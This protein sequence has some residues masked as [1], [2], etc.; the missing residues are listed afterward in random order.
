[1]DILLRVLAFAEAHPEIFTRL[2]DLF[3]NTITA[4]PELVTGLVNRF[5]PPPPKP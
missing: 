4:H 3:S 2:L 5:A 1:M